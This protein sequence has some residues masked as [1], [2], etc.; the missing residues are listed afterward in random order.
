VLS[1]P[2]SITYNG[3]AKSLPR[4]GVAKDYSVYGS[5]DNEF[6]FTVESHKE[7]ND[8][9]VKCELVRSVPDPTPSNAFD[10]YREVNVGVGLT[11]RFDTAT[12]YDVA[13]VVPYLRTALLAL[14][15]STL[16]S[17]LIAGEK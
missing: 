9:V 4:L 15:D 7:D 16:Q 10:A 1:D 11:F 14:V 6:G 13:T 3:S 8:T 2:L 5:S 17:R 12:R